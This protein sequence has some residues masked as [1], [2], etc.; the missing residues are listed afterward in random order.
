MLPPVHAMING[1]PVD[2]AAPA[3]SVLDRGFLYGDGV[4]E[5]LRTYGGR[6]CALED[7]LAR[8]SAAAGALGITM[9]PTARWISEVHALLGGCTWGESVVRLILTR[10]VGAPGLK[11]SASSSPTRVVMVHPLPPDRTLAERAV[12]VI[13][14]RASRSTPS[15]SRKT[16]E[17][18]TSIWALRQA[19]AA[20]ADDAI[21]L[22]G[23]GRL[24]EAAT[25]NVLVVSEGSLL[26]TPEGVGLPGVTRS[27]ILQAARAEGVPVILRPLTAADLWTA[28]EVFLSASL[29][30]LVPVR[31]VDDHEVPLAP[32]EITERLHRRY[33]SLI[34]TR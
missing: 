19:D 8:M 12:S 13:T 11:P 18:L 22:D 7:H 28:D 17:Y 31:A 25:A 34:V 30:E 26:S 21:L 14:L 16:L 33:R 2:P 6:P 29:R 24:V 9:A 10:G 23:D 20:G 32:G 15:T 4:F 5:V 3:I 27:L 1:A